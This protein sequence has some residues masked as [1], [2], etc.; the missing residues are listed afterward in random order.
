MPQ[1]F[2]PRDR[3]AEVFG[4]AQSP[5]DFSVEVGVLDFA[6]DEDADIRFDDVG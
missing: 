5:G 4:G 1:H 3:F 2:L 6:D